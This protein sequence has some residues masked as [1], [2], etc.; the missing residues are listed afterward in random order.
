M[1]GEREGGVFRS[2]VTRWTVVPAADRRNWTDVRL[3]IKF[4]FENPLYSA[5]SSAVADRLAPVMIDA[6]VAQAA[7]VLSGPGPERRGQHPDR[8]RG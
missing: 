5:V 6:F 1:G 4:Q 8:G 3:D 7:R 2:L